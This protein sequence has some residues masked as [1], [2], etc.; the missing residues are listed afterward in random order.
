MENIKKED[1]VAEND[2]FFKDDH[3]NGDIG[4]DIIKEVEPVEKIDEK[5]KDL[6]EG[7]NDD[8]F[9][10][11][12]NE[13]VEVENTVPNGEGVESVDEVLS[14]LKHLKDKKFINFTEDE[15]SNVEDKGFFLEEKLKQLLENNVKDVFGKLPDSLK[16]INKYVY[17]GGNINDYITNLMNNQVDLSPDMDIENENN[18]VLILKKLLEKEGFDNDDIE[19]QIE[20]YKEKDNLGS[21]AK[22]KFKNWSN[23]YNNKQKEL[24]VQQE[25]RNTEEL[26]RFNEYKDNLQDIVNNSET[27]GDIKLPDRAKK[28][29]IPYI[30]QKSFQLEDGTTISQRDN[31][32]YEVLKSPK[33][34]LQLAYLLQNLNEDKTFN[35]KQLESRVK[36]K[37]TREI[38]NNVKNSVNNRPKVGKAPIH[39]PMDTQNLNAHILKH[40]GKK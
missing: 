8:N 33:G 17:N 18:Q 20:Y 7:G 39:M 10:E 27:I 30:T 6:G 15:L 37:I 22:T 21:I 35:F 24:S 38:Q 40:F 9:W 12:G 29:I 28:N 5:E 13:N 14:A 3:K 34:S 2:D 16:E 26:K 32:L 31:D 1:L 4:D 11:D 36:T 19:T 25:L 23:D